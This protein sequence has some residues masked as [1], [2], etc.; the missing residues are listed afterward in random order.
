MIFKKQQEQKQ[1]VD[2]LLQLSP[3]I[4]DFFHSA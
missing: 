3:N 4:E 2:R 1:Q